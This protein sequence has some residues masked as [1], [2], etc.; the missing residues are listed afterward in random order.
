MIFTEISSKELL[1]HQSKNNFR[2]YYSQCAE[3]S[4]L[5]TLNNLKNKILAVKHGD[6]ILAYGIFS[7]YRHKKFFYNVVSQYGPVM[8]YSNIEL[9]NFY[10]DNLLKYFKKDI[11]VTSVTVNPFINAKKFRD[12]EYVGNNTQSDDLNHYLIEKRFKSTNID[13]YENPTLPTTC[14]FSKEISEIK[15]DDILAN[16]SQIARYTINKTKKEGVLIRDLNLE[17]EEERKIFDEITQ[18]TN[19]RLGVKLR[20]SN[21]SLKNKRVFKDKCHVKLAYIDCDLFIKNTSKTIENLIIEKKELQNKI[22]EGAVNLKKSQNKLREFD[23]NIDIW[24]KKIDKISKLKEE[25][26]NILNVS[27]AVY[28]ESGQDFIY[29][30]SANIQKYAHFEG[31]Y[32][33]T[34]EMMKYAIEKGFKYYNFYG[35]SKDLSENSVDYKVLQF[36]RNF[37]GNIEWFMDNYEIKLN[38]GKFI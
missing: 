28:F 15:S 10:F 21:Q 37:N 13:F 24:N 19:K 30:S 33:L 38:L 36:K 25:N 16:I 3:Y 31:P 18:D 29:F 34:Y 17:I 7:Y 26:G 11:R 32:A 9:R 27:Y 5:A 14:V 4:E 23:E 12:I 6:D 22:N 20:D 2:Y 8:D 35:T 1:E